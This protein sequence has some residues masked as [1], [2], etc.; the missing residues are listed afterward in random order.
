MNSQANTCVVIGGAGFI[1]SHVT[2]LLCESGREVVVVGRRARADR[3][4]HPACRYLSGDY[5]DRAFLRSVL[6][7]GCE[8]I[9]LAY[10]T[11]PKTSF[12]DP[13]FDL[14]S[15]LPASVGLF[16]EALAAGVRRV[17]IVSSGGTVYGPTDRL[18]IREDHPTVPVSPYGIT[19]L[20]TDRYAMM[21]HRNEG[22]P[23]MVVRPANAYGEDQRAGT[24]QG[25][26]A[27]AV[28]AV[29]S[30]REIEIYGREGTVRDYIHVSDVAAGIV[31]ALDHGESG[32]IYN[33]G[34]GVGTSNAGIVRMLEELA[35]DQ[36]ITVNTKILPPRHF[37]VEANILDSTKLR[38]KSGWAPAVVLEDGLL[39]VWRAGIARK[40]G[41]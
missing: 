10:S 41:S 34:T 19:K 9:D 15:N 28:A 40:P 6:K 7:P 37:D 31:A 20:A 17:L 8:V 12:E 29:L 14:L 11:V 35:R 18:P 25:F 13:V 36:G 23:V 32:E 24:G 38:M 3:D 2:R 21:F 39:R 26:I 16:Q 27:A 4:L 22:L 33:I 5:S 1:G 30:G